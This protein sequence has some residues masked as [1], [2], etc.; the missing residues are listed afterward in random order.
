MSE[1]RPDTVAGELPPRPG[2][3]MSAIGAVP[4]IALTAAIGL[5]LIA[6]GYTA[7]R[8]SVARCARSCTG[9]ALPRSSCRPPSPSCGRRSRRDNVLH[10]VRG[11]P[12]AL[13]R[14]GRARPDR[15]HAVRR[16]PP[17]GDPQQHG[18]VAP[19]L[20]PEQHPARQ[21]VL[22]GPGDR[23]GGAGQHGRPGLACGDVADRRG[24]AASRVSLYLFVEAVSRSPRIAAMA[25][26][27][28]MA[29][30]SFLIFDAQFA[31]ESLALP[32]ALFALFCVLRRVEGP[33]RDAVAI[34][35]AFL[36]TLFSIIV[37]HHITSIALALFLMTLGSHRIHRSTV[38]SL[39]LGVDPR[40]A[41]AGDRGGRRDD[42][43]DPLCRD[44]HGRV[45]GSGIP[46][47]AAAG[48][49]ADQRHRRRP[50]ALSG[51]NRR[52]GADVG[53]HRGLRRR[54]PD[55]R[56]AALRSR[57]ALADEPHEPH[58]PGVGS[59]SPWPTQRR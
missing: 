18:R 42:R 53:A 56:R 27:L 40:R 37:T 26:L 24:A 3:V 21:S 31:Y 48:S 45:P 51:G 5:F 55:P 22:P 54:R 14:Q 41:W 49:V 30:P 59:W 33:R 13:W 11:R 35:I 29:N 36:I 9:P 50:R 47:R 57:R 23:D 38:G 28:Y 12:G 10:P 2:G 16:V 19:S 39:G 8:F 32:L 58:G 46:G 7:G 4:A 43:L 52:T 20:R 15:V 25:T 44:R 17:R 34:T 1:V 6:C